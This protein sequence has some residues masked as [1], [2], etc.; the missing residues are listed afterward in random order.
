[1]LTMLWS[2]PGTPEITESHFVTLMATGAAVSGIILGWAIYLGRIVNTRH[3]QN[4]RIRPRRF[5]RTRNRF[6]NRYK[7]NLFGFFYP[8]V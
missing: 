1:M 7:K 4:N 8:P 3:A 5:I 2:W 6:F